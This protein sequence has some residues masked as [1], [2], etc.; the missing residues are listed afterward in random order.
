M[1]LWQRHHLEAQH[2]IYGVR[3]LEVPQFA[4]DS[5]MDAGRY[6]AAPEHDVVAD[7][8]EEIRLRLWLLSIAESHQRAPQLPQEKP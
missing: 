1:K 6:S 3:G 7:L 5:I 8:E 4:I 2:G